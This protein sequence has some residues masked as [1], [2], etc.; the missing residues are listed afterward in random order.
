[1][2]WRKATLAQGSEC[3]I[4]GFWIHSI[5]RLHHVIPV[6]RDGVNRPENLVY[7]CPNC[8][9]IVHEAAKRLRDK[10]SGDRYFEFKRQLSDVYDD[11]QIATIEN[12]AV[13]AR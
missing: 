13:Q 12:Y 5:L 4:C 9:A 2:K 8:H 11:N 3:E 10:K 1:M 7:L 6:S